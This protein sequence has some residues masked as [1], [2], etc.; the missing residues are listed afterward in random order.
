[1]T[2][3]SVNGKYMLKE[4]IRRDKASVAVREEGSI[5]LC[6]AEQVPVF[7][8]GLC[9]VITRKDT[10]H[11]IASDTHTEAVVRSALQHQPQVLLISMDI[12]PAGGLQ[13]VRS[14]RRNGVQGRVVMYGKWDSST[15]AL[16]AR[17][18]GI[19]GMVSR[20]DPCEEYISAIE[21]A[22]KGVA[23]TSRSVRADLEKIQPGA[24]GSE[25]VEELTA[26]EYH[27]LT[28]LSGSR[29]SVEIANILCISVRTVEKHRQNIGRKL[30]IHGINAL[31]S[32]ALNHATVLQA[33]NH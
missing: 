19:T 32:Y 31:L 17:C 3:S 10:I 1:M 7:C 23:F 14:L 28:L 29:T 24:D 8:A 12:P 16:A 33:A 5:S 2:S 27:V 4:A 21:H 22:A 9:D 25:G 15:Q 20:N 18:L 6:I 26:T 11:L 30:N 13:A